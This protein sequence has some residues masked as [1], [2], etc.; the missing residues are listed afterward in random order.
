V[1]VQ[2]GAAT[3]IPQS[4]L[5]GPRLLQEVSTHIS[6]VARLQQMGEAARRL[7]KPDAARD[8]AKVVIELARRKEN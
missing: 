5:N 8:M 2:A 3:I 6:D 7:S 1:N 4:E